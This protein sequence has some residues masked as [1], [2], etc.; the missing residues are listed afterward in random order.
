MYS[1]MKKA[2]DTLQELLRIRRGHAS[3]LI[4]EMAGTA[5]KRDDVQEVNGATATRI[6][7][8][9]FLPCI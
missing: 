4:C 6:L 5:R 3:M 8:E 1:D 2:T 9:A 7:H